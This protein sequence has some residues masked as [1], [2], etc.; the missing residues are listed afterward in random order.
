MRPSLAALGGSIL[1]G[2]DT[3][4]L[5]AQPLPWLLEPAASNP[6]HS[7]AF[8]FP[9]CMMNAETPKGEG[10][11]QPSGMGAPEGA[12]SGGSGPHDAAPSSEKEPAGAAAW[13]KCPCSQQ[14]VR[15]PT[16]SEAHQ[17][18]QGRLLGPRRLYAEARSGGALGIIW[19]LPKGAECASAP[20]LL[21]TPSRQSG[22]RLCCEDAQAPRRAQ[23]GRD[24]RV[25]YELEGGD[26][27][28]RAAAAAGRGVGPVGAACRRC[29]LGSA[30]HLATPASLGGESA[31][32][33]SS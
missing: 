19:D 20:D 22:G 14:P 6:A 28:A 23:R 27:H 16:A 15:S 21:L 30:K 9:E 13:V 18:A 7:T 31:L 8:D 26:G 33:C 2:V 5:G 17:L 4:R 24:C 10:I 32:T 3:G 29:H 1:T 25:G 12:P 11:D